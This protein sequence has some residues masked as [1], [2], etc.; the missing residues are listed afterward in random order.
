VVPNDRLWV[1]PNGIAD[2]PAEMRRTG[3]LGD[4]VP[5]LVMVARFAPPKLQTELIVAL[6]ELADARWMLRLVGDGPQL[7]DCRAVVARLGL[8]ERVDFLGHRDDVADVLASSDI[9]LLWSRYEG[10]PISVMEYMRA[11]LCCAAGDLPGVRELLGPD[12][13]VV[14]R[15][16]VELRDELR[17]LLADR[18]AIDALGE[19]AR[20][21]YIERFSAE[22]MV[23]ATDAVYATVRGRTRQPC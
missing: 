14:A 22:S 17:R 4:R 16:V 19:A 5:V 8:G 10:L 12:G 18:N 7:D 13:G 6:A 3:P 2:V 15:S 1:V 23:A 20:R 21:R 9:G 11:G